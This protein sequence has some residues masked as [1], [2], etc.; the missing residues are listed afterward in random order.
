[1]SRL[2]AASE[3]AADGAGLRRATS[4]SASSTSSD[5]VYGWSAS[6]CAR[7]SCPAASRCLEAK[8]D[9]G[10]QGFSASPEVS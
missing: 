1:M 5:R 7:R 2:A 10:C 3:F 4:T 8:P 9:G 6:I